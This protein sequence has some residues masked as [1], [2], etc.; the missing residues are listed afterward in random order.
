MSKRIL[1]AGIGNIFL[2]DDAFGVE[3]VRRL[4]GC[5]MPQGVVVRDFGI[6]GLDLTYAL[7]DGWEAVVMVDAMP[8]GE[9]PGTLFVIEPELDEPPLDEQGKPQP[10]AWQPHQLDPARVL[11]MVCAMGGQ[12]GWMR[13]V[14][15]EPT[16]LDAYDVL[17]GLSPPVAAAIEP[18]TRLVISVVEQ[19]AA[20][21][22]VRV[23]QELAVNQVS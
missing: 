5:A 17:S 16:P 14:G 8:R 11:Q 19:F 23:H 2:G 18:A 13:L 22:V 9:P 20:E 1:I 3:V 21:N 4:A 12:V 15:C 10:V 6:R 7:L